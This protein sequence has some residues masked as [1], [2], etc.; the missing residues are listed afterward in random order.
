MT[1]KKLKFKI[2]EEQKLLAQTI[3]EQKGKRKDVPY[4]YVNG[5]DYNRDD[6]RHIHIMYCHFFNK[7]PY[8]MIE[9]ECHTDPSSRRLDKLRETWESQIE[10]AL[11]DCA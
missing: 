9:R 10:E 3:K 2:K 7:T 8:S 1:F 5:L 4:G 6:Y 11:C